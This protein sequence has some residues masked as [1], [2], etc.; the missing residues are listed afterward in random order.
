MKATRSARALA[1]LMLAWIATATATAAESEIWVLRAARYVG[2]EA[3]RVLAPAVLVVA[4]PRIVAINP[5]S[6]S[7]RRRLPC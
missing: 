7:T 6:L 4:G 2:V 5:P 3:G 1:V